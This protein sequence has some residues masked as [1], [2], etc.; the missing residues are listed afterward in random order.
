MHLPLAGCADG[1]IQALS[2]VLDL[3]TTYEEVQKAADIL[4]PAQQSL[5]ASLRY[6]SN[7][8][9]KDTGKEGQPQSQK[10]QKVLEE[11]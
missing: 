3:N 4:L 7:T 6:H 5:R 2:M 9:G 11:E 8:K 1:E 10:D